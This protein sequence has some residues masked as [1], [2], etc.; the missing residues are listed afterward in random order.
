M[1]FCHV[2]SGVIDEGV[3]RADFS[4]VTA[5]QSCPVQLHEADAGWH[6]EHWKDFPT[7]AA[8]EGGESQPREE[9]GM[10]RVPGQSPRTT[11]PLQY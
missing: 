8:E 2:L 6:P 9:Q 3:V 4:D 7:K 5:L 11:S 10:C 1:L